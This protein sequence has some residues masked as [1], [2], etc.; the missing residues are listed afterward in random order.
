MSSSSNVP[1][2]VA[3][4]VHEAALITRDV[5]S[6]LDRL[7]EIVAILAEKK[8]PA[9]HQSSSQQQQQLPFNSGTSS[10]DQWPSASHTTNMRC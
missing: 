10:Q 8:A 9:E 5:R 3:L 4:L 1:Y 6:K 2:S 7:E